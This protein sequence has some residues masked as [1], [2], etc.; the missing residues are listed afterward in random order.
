MTVGKL[1]ARGG[2]VPPPEELTE[3]ASTHPAPPPTGEVAVDE[4]TVEQLTVAL[5]HTTDRS[6]RLQQARRDRSES[7][8]PTRVTANDYICRCCIRSLRFDCHVCL[9]RLTVTSDCCV[10]LLHLIVASDCYIRL[11]HLIVTSHCYI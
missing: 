1:Q 6:Q 4:R 10:C 8:Q 7:V 3:I 9:P 2:K 11:L 5:A